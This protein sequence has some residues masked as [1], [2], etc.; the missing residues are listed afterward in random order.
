MPS[1]TEN[2]KR[3]FNLAT[4]RNRAKGLSRPA[5]LEKLSEITRRYEREANK[6][7]KL[8][9]RDYK[10][11]VEKA[12]QARIN[13]AG[14]KDLTLKHRLFGSDNFDKAAL[15]RA[16]RRDVQHD[17]ARRMAHLERGE[18]RELDTLVATAEQRQAQ[19][20]ERRETP[21]ESLAKENF[22]RA[23]TRR[24]GVERRQQTRSDVP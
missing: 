8:Y 21:K 24:S 2:V 7:E 17:H 3:V 14:A 20:S 13:K 22:A 16:A 4:M 11:R 12:L 23:T 6:Q 15:T 9:R 5:D 18:T 19:S 10:S 1:T